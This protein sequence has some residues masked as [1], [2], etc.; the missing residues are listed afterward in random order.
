MELF[1]NECTPVLSDVHKLIHMKYN[2]L[3]KKEVECY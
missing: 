1:G 3:G 2:V